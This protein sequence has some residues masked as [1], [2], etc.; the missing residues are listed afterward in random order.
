M[1]ATACIVICRPAL[2]KKGVQKALRAG[3]LDR[4]EKTAAARKT[5]DFKASKIAN[6]D[7]NR[8]FISLCEIA[9][10]T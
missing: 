3:C 4:K 7:I 6:K 2:H 8:H 5:A 9:Q 1:H 10:A